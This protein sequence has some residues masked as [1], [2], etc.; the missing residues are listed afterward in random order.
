VRSRQQGFIYPYEL[1]KL[2]TPP[3]G[4]TIASSAGIPAG[5]FF[6]HDLD[7]HNR[8]VPVTRPMGQNRRT[9]SSPWCGVSPPS[10]PRASP[11]GA[12]WRTPAAT[13]ARSRNPSAAASIAPVDL[14][15]QKRV[16]VEWF[17]LSAGARISMESGTEN[18][19]WIALVLRRLVTFTQRAAK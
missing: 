3:R 4:G 19:D 13:L 2:M 12:A 11:R 14:A 1:L 16:A 17:A 15:E 6:E 9:S 10:S 7:A 8:L 5:E 18:M